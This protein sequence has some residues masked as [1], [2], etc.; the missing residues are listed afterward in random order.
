[1]TIVNVYKTVF[2]DYPD[3]L[4]VTQMSKALGICTK[5]AYTTPGNI[6]CRDKKLFDQTLL[7]E[8]VEMYFAM[9]G[10][11]I[12]DKILELD[13]TQTLDDVSRETLVRD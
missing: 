8:N 12:L 6:K 3:V 4:S 10:C 7:K 9:G 13:N 11:E 2:R 5:T 1:M